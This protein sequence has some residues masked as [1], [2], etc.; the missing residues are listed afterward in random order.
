VIVL[1]AANDA[2]GEANLVLN[3]AVLTIES[4]L[5]NRQWQHCQLVCQRDRSMAS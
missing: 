5:G 3:G 2:M 4:T 1:D